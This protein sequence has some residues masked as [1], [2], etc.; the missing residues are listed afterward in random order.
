MINRIITRPVCRRAEQRCSLLQTASRALLA[1]MNNAGKP[2]PVGSPFPIARTL[3]SLSKSGTG[4]PKVRG[5]I[6][7]VARVTLPAPLHRAV[8]SATRS[9]THYLIAASPA[10]M[11]PETSASRASPTATRTHTG[12]AILTSAAASLVKT[13]RSIRNGSSSTSHAKSLSTRSRSPGPT[14]TPPTMSSNT[15][16]A[17]I[18]STSP[19][20]AP[21]L[22]SLTGLS[23]RP[24]A[25]WQPTGSPTSPS[26]SAS[27]ASG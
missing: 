8:L 2:S 14:P 23:P 9:V 7:P 4:T 5:A 3:T 1:G 24:M 10:T 11:A 22:P 21:G 26:A 20:A 15:G 16:P 6:L 19:P 25:V 18:P 12:R 17:S 13:T 27:S